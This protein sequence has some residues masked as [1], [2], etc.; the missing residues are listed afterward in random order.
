MKKNL[1]I[2]LF[3]FSLLFSVNNYTFADTQ[4]TNPDTYFKDNN[5]DPE[6]GV[7]NDTAGSNTTTKSDSTTKTPDSSNSSSSGGKPNCTY[8][9]DNWNIKVWSA[10]D[11]CL[12][13]SALVDWSNVTVNKGWFADKVINWVDNI[14]IYLWVIAVGSIVY[15]ALIM[16]LSAWED[17]KITKAK[18]IIK[19]WI[20]WFIW[21][22]SAAA[23]INLV[24]SIMYSL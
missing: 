9:A 7:Y 11:D 23:I 3:S 19:W 22:I 24:V 4:Y 16:T 10:L 1:L 17:E 21:L 2:I 12:A 8:D 5:I 14:S 20:V 13:W 6:T 18:N 15:W